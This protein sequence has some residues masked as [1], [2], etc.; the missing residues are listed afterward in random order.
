MSMANR[1]SNAFNREDGIDFVDSVM[2]PVFVLATVS[3]TQL[4]E[5]STGTFPFDWNFTDVIFAA[6][7][8]EITWA[9]AITM[10]TI[11]AAWISNG[12][13]SW[14][15][16]N[17]MESM[18]VALMVLLNVFIALVPA[19]QDTVQTFWWVGFTMVLLNAAG[20][21]VLAYK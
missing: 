13:T 15:D 7:G 9:F 21:W 18:V 19:V 1:A 2:A 14:D 5:F 6:S 20:F 12:I 17:D 3:M 16:L 8:S 11:F 10:V 4:F